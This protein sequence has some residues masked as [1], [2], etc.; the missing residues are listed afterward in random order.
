M[1]KEDVEEFMEC[2]TCRAKPGS[3]Y[4]CR[5]CLHNR[6]LINKLTPLV[7]QKE[8]CCG[9]WTGKES[10]DCDREGA[11]TKPFT[12]KCL[13]HFSVDN[14]TTHVTIS[15]PD[16]WECQRVGCNVDFYHT[17]ST[18]A[19]L[20]KEQKEG[21]VNKCLACEIDKIGRIYT[22][23]EHTCHTPTVNDEFFDLLNK[24]QTHTPATQVEEQ[25]EGVECCDLC[26]ATLHNGVWTCWRLFKGCCHTPQ[27]STPQEEQKEGVAGIDTITLQNVEVQANGIIRNSKG[28]L[29]ARLVPGADFE[30]EHVKGLHTPTPTV[31]EE[32]HTQGWKIKYFETFS[33]Q[34]YQIAR[35]ADAGDD[36]GYGRGL[37]RLQIDIEA[38][39]QQIASQEY[40]RGT[41]QI[42]A[43]G[44]L[45]KTIAT[46]NFEAG[47]L[48]GIADAVAVVPEESVIDE[49]IFP[50]Q[51]FKATY[52]ESGGWNACR[53]AV[54]TALS[55][56]THKE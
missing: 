52:D 11:R 2:D 9:E 4:L 8:K 40:E 12:C 53:Q 17:H 39:I 10:Y 27:T 44:E 29:I 22:P 46:R 55:S 20:K 43:R 51:T 18:Y 31:K 36:E 3:P 25:K 15:T 13:C 35:L 48:Q 37:A 56:L 34:F 42:T 14:G 24:G 45:A 26:R 38:Y 41:Q 5:G 32:S 30:S 23:L 19:A 47:R 16:G 49:K 50:F 28:R 1:S 6:T 33:E 7:A 54:L 21:V